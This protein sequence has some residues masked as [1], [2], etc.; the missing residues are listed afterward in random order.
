MSPHEFHYATVKPIYEGS[1]HP[2]GRAGLVGYGDRSE[3]LRTSEG[4]QTPP[5]SEN[6]PDGEVDFEQAAHNGEMATRAAD[7][8]F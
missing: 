2:I 7:V 3:G 6:Q 8:Q 4:G 5:T 1:C